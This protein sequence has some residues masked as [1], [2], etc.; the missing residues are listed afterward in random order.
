MCI[1]KTESKRDEWLKHTATH[2]NKLQHTATHIPCDEHRDEWLR[3]I[4]YRHAFSHRTQRHH[5]YSTIITQYARTTRIPQPFKGKKG[6][7]AIS[8]VAQFL[9]NTRTHIPNASDRRK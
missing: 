2:C 8:A 4:H 6:G 7:C 1:G 9:T 5:K 3:R